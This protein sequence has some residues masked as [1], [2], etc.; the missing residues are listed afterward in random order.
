[1]DFTDITYYPTYV[2]WVINVDLNIRVGR[3]GGHYDLN[4][5]KS[6]QNY[7][8][9]YSSVNLKVNQMEI[10]RIDHCLIYLLKLCFYEKNIFCN[11][12]V[13]GDNVE[14]Y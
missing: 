8:D 11:F 6:G 13:G 7:I 3:G 1:M 9:N 4:I 14:K 12:L 2:K 10:S 5:V